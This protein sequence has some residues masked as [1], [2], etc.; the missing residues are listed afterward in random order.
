MNALLSLRGAFE[1]APLDRKT[2]Y[3]TGAGTGTRRRFVDVF[4]SP[5]FLER[6]ANR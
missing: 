3:K 1:V 5:S 6:F 4:A 2:L